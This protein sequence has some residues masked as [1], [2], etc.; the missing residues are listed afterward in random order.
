VK[1]FTLLLLAVS[2]RLFAQ[3]AAPDGF[4]ASGLSASSALLS[5]NDNSADETGFLVE[6]STSETSGFVLV[7]TTASNATSYINT[8]LTTGTQY[9]YRIRAMGASGNSVYTNV[10]PFITGIRRFLID[11]GSTT[12]PTTAAGWNNITLPTT[13]S[14]TNLVENS[15]SASTVSLQIVNDPS[16]G[17]QNATAS[18][19]KSTLL[20][21]PM[22][23]CQ[24]GHFGYATGG[25]YKINGLNN[26]MNYSLRFFGSRTGVTD[27]RKSVFTIN[28]QSK[29]LETSNNTSQ[30]V[31]FIN[32]VPTNGSIIIDFTVGV[33][34]NYAYINV[35]DVVEYQST[36]PVPTALSAH[37]VSSTRI[38]L[39]WQDNSSNETSF[40]IERSLTS[41]SG[42][43][44]IATVVA[45]STSFVDEGLLPTS[46]YY[47]RLRAINALGSS[48]YS[49]EV[50]TATLA[51]PPATPTS[52]VATAIDQQIIL[53]W[54]DAANNETGFRIERS[55]SS[56]F[57]FTQV[58]VVPMNTTT[59]TDAGLSGDTQYFYRVAAVNSG[60][61]SAYSNEA[62][63]TTLPA[64]PITPSQLSATTISA[65]EINLIWNDVSTNELG[66]QVEQAL[67]SGGEFVLIATIPSNTTQ[68]RVQGLSPNSSYF[69]LV[70][71]FNGAGASA[72][73]AE[74]NSTTLPLPPAP[75]IQLTANALSTTQISLVWLDQSDNETGF[76]L[77][78]SLTA[79]SG[80]VSVATISAND[81]LYQD[82]NLITETTYFY[83][84]RAFN[85]GGNSVFT[86]VTSATTQ[87][88]PPPAP[89]NL[90]AVPTSTT[91][92][93]LTWTDASTNETGFQIERSS[94]SG[95]GFTLLFATNANTT[96]FTDSGLSP[97][98]LY[99]YRVRAINALGQSNYTSEV[100]AATL[101]LIQ[102]YGEIFN[103]TSF[104]SAT[105]FPIVG[106]SITRSTN[107]L[108]LSGAP[109]F[110]KSY[111]YHDD[112]NS[113]FRYTCLENWKT[114]VRLKTPALF[115][116]TSHGVSIGVVSSNS[117]N[118]YSTLLRWSWKPGNGKIY[119]YYKATTSKQIIST[120]AFAPTAN[121]FYWIEVTR[122]KD[123]FTYT[124]LDGATG[125]IQLYSTTLTFPTF[126]TANYVKA[127][128]TGQFCIQQFG[129]TKTEVTNWQ[130]STEAIKNADFIGVGD[131]NMHGMFATG[132][133]QRFVENAMTTAN[134][135]FNILAGTADRTVE[136]VQRLPEIIALAPKAVVLSIG[137]ND[138][139][140]SIPLA[141][142]QE[143][144]TTIINTLEAAGITVYLAGVI[145]SNTN[146]SALQTFY[147]SK[148]NI[149]VNSF[150]A[151]KSAT[152]NSL[153]SAYN[154]GDAIHLNSAGN[155]LLSNLLSTII[156]APILVAPNALTATAASKSQIK[157][158]WTDNSTN[159]TGFQIERSLTAITGFSTLA[160]V[161]ANTTSFQD[162]GLQ[163]NT[164]YFYRVRAIATVGHSGYTAESNS[165]SFGESQARSITLPGVQREDP[166]VSSET[167]LEV[168]PNPVLG[169]LTVKVLTATQQAISIYLFDMQGRAIL[170]QDGN[171][172]TEHT[173]DMTGIM[174][175]L[176]IIK[177]TADGKVLSRLVL[178]E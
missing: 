133:S 92:I 84:I 100:S 145:A 65:S 112:P 124:I 143:N 135:S 21:Y 117:Y 121:T 72:Y 85:T 156:T 115:D 142:V 149:K 59:F 68:Y 157:L 80:F 8:G 30:T 70:R 2:V 7:G 55:F 88:G 56:G 32:I 63:A 1:Y 147:N 66:F 13:G 118:P 82:S 38:N 105:R 40:E 73:S 37:A 87:A 99:F 33:G 103:E 16:D 91:Q 154:S 155:T 53:N 161:A 69:F 148:S 39:S 173:V 23:A 98:N 108:V 171:T 25:T 94:T 60:G 107:K 35:L 174:P 20:D 61:S 153:A 67:T 95:S 18:G 122:N 62:S 138:L 6:R 93:Y 169:N 96:S 4:S 139:T 172:T 144:I 3:T 123:S 76:Q 152:T 104:I 31:L 19:Y 89:T 163:A 36:P 176:F 9:Y 137:R 166:S 54:I 127:H 28:G 131:S 11:F 116:I 48:A 126:T 27:S 106:T 79:E 128:N 26:A 165:Q 64:P 51:V 119:M 90:G 41:G 129:G 71:A 110:F 83:R 178:K 114:R 132:N 168:Y 34:S 164:T 146:V 102:P 111:V 50:N 160:T 42:F 159:E 170:R 17:Y 120:T 57:G 167:Q 45:N 49:N 151:T 15:G 113:P 52:F 77:E 86:E 47:Y 10:I 43:T 29:I 24:D 130:V 58:T 136:V 46:Q 134:R 81:I 14:V 97:G 78:R 74:V 162:V 125:T 177:V 109:G 140:N 158:S 12:Y 175:G 75:P 22:T 150:A 141:T 5:W 101:T 44:A